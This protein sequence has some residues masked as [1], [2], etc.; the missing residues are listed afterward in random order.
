LGDS[1][2]RERNGFGHGHDKGNRNGCPQTVVAVTVVVALTALEQA[3]ARSDMAVDPNAFIDRWHE[4]IY[5]RD[6]AGLTALLADDVK[7]FSPVVFRPYQG[8]DAVGFVFQHVAAVLDDFRYV[9]TY[10][11]PDGGVVMRFAAS[12]QDEDRRLEVDG[13]DIMALDDDGRVSELSVMMRPLGT[14]QKVGNAMRKRILG[15]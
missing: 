12:F 6:I 7:M 14:L 15:Q 4:L 3:R 8:R 5:A 13:V 1:S 11:A 10:V 9:N 2:W